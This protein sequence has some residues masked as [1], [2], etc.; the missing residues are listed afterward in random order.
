MDKTIC[1]SPII[2]VTDTSEKQL[3]T[4]CFENFMS[5]LDK[6]QVY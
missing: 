6:H 1:S 4:F 2:V 5:L 3:E